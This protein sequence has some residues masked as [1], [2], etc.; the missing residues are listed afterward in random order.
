MAQHSQHPE[1]TGRKTVMISCTARDLPEHRQE[2]KEACLRQGMF[3]S[4]ME[5]LPASDSEAIAASLKMVDEA[6]IYLGIFAH[7]YG[8][9]PKGYDISIT[10]MEYSRAVER[11]IPRLIFLMHEDHPIKAADVEKGEGAV[12]LEA[13]KARLG[14]ERVVNFFTSPADLRAHV[15]NSLSQYRQPNLTVFHYVSDIPAPPEPYIAHPYTLLQTHTLIGRQAELNLLTDWVTNPKSDIYSARVLNIVAIGGLGKSALTWKWF[16]D[17][18]PH[19]MQPLAGRMW[20]SFYESDATF[21][22]FVIR[23]LAYVTRRARED[24]QKI[25]PP[26]R[27]D[28][29]LAVL[30][31]EPYLLVL[32]GLERILIA[33][34]RM[35]AA[36]LADDDLDQRT[37]N[38]VAGAYG[39]PESAA[40]SFIGQHRLRKT[41]APRVGNFLRKLAGVWSARILISTR[42]YPADLQTDAGNE[43][44]GSKGIFLHGLSDDDALNLWRAFGVSG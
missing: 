23:A 35:D 16:N 40:Q 43:R 31:R 38:V 32:D 39:L 44:P 2:V 41:A 1:P 26:E 25:P 8:Y 22:N 19:E 9:V 10:E 4:M 34:A 11:G 5:H 30:D 37:A 12:K 27:E 18:A 14:T 29:L 6:D 42:L 24:I 21:E 33:Y 15:I 20:W 13:L 36:R 17:I 28:Q 3:P 7:R